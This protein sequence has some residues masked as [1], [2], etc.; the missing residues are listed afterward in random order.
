[1][2]LGVVLKPEGGMELELFPVYAKNRFVDRMEEEKARNFMNYITEISYG[3]TVD[4]Q[5]K[6]TK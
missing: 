6:V 4:E 1:M 5:G 2:M 3:V